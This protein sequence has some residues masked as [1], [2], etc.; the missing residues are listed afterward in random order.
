MDFHHNVNLLE[1]KVTEANIA[2]YFVV[3]QMMALPCA[4]LHPGRIWSSSDPTCKFAAKSWLQ[5]P[6]RT[7]G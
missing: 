2:N 4:S 5:R 3:L 1:G 7:A 6:F